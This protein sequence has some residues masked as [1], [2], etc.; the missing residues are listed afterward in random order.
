MKISKLCIIYLIFTYCS[1]SSTSKKQK[2]CK[3]FISSEGFKHSD[4]VIP[5][6]KKKNKCP[7]PAT[8]SLSECIRKKSCVVSGITLV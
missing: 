2:L 5:T 3:T 6:V 4:N 7:Q 1:K 8:L